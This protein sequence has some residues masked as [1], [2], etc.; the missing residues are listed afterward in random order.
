M[1]YTFPKGSLRLRDEF[2]SSCDKEAL[3]ELDVT[4]ED[5][6]CDKIFCASCERCWDC[7]EG[8]STPEIFC[9]KCFCSKCGED[10]YKIIT[11]MKPMV[12]YE[13]IEEAEKT[14]C[15]ITH[16]NMCQGRAQPV[17]DMMKVLEMM[18]LG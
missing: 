14:M 9:S 1:S 17:S 15:M 2:C 16:N 18:D 13:T 8:R 12:E 6:R 5:K 4:D 11:M 10:Y 7:E 3:Y